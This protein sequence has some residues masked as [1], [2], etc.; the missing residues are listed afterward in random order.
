MPVTAKVLKLYN[1]DSLAYK[2]PGHVSEFFSLKRENELVL[3]Y[4]ICHYMG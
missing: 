1:V 3:T 2:T 4:Y